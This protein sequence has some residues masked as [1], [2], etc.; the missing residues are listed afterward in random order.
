MTAPEGSTQGAVRRDYSA[1][2][3]YSMHALDPWPLRGFSQPI[4]DLSN[5]YRFR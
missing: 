3:V 2:R 1:A 5:G 4:D